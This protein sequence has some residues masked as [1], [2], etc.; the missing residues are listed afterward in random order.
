LEIHACRQRRSPADRTRRR[1][2]V[3]RASKTCDAIRAKV[4]HAAATA[5]EGP[6]AGQSAGDLTLRNGAVVGANGATEKLED[7]FR[8]MG[9][10]SI[11][12]YSEF[13]PDGLRPEAITAL[14]DGRL[15][16]IGGPHDKKVMYA[17]GAE[18]EVRVHALTR[19]IRVPR[20][21]GAFAAGRL[22]N[23]R[24]VHSQLMG[25]MIWGI[26]SA[27]HEATEIDLQYAR[28]TNDNLWK[29]QCEGRNRIGQFG[30]WFP[31][32]KVSTWTMGPM[33]FTCWPSCAPA[34]C[35]MLRFGSLM[36][37]PKPLAG[38]ERDLRRRDGD[39]L[40]IDTSYSCVGRASI[41]PHCTDGA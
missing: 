6:L 1:A 25:G 41:S 39:L 17:C 26:S 37:W 40:S 14:Y 12:E 33:H 5:N 3:A 34:I 22:M 23:T 24:T 28:Y 20:I 7:I 4:F 35:P 30:A 27:L 31:V 32:D 38:T 2:R 18:L 13:V 21:V 8:R 9:V 36:A 19:E 15:T 29:M 10:S 16:M 11:E